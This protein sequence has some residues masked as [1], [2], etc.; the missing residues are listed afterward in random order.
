MVLERARAEGTALTYDDVRLRPDYSEVLPNQVCLESK[1]SRNVG[2]KIPIVS[3]AMDTVTEHELAIELAKL[4]GI[5]V[6]HKGMDIERQLD[7]VSKVKFHLNGLIEK[8]ICVGEDEKISSILEKREKKGYT[9]HSFLVV[10]NDEKLVGIITRNDF[11][12]WDSK[13]DVLAREIM[14]TDLFCAPGGTTI[15]DAYD[16]MRNEKKK[17][18]PLVSEKGEIAGMYVFSDVKRIKTRE[19]EAYNVDSRGQLRVAAAV[20]VGDEALERVER[21]K[22]RA[23][24]IVIDTAHGDSRG[25]FDTLR[26]IK[27]NY[28]SLDVVA[29][30]VSIGAA[31]KR[32]VD[33]GA[34][35]VKVG[36]GP[37][38]I[39][40]TRVV[41]GIGR[42]QVSAV[43]D[44]AMEIYDLGIPI[45]ADGGLTNPGDIPIAITAG[46]HSVMMGS[47]LAGTEEAPG[48]IVFAEG[49]QWKNYRGMGSV[50]A[51]RDSRGAKERYFQ[52]GSEESKLVPEGI[53]GLT[54]YKGRLADVVHQYVG[55]LRAGMGYAGTRSIK[56]LIEGGDFDRITSAGLSESHPH[57]VSMIREAPNYTPKSS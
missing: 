6:I 49:R 40:T 55:G 24:V 46:A 33:A 52:E 23:D 19:A 25:V 57:G 36:Q 13:D 17:I 42:P 7:E 26:E 14:S 54:P 37:G 1:F 43:Y 28:D 12:F 30:N 5:G 3:A 16:L 15:D 35:G 4:G 27:R 45:C 32:L 22:G 56:E 20:G 21:L 10:N 41:A 2:L 8:P 50:G 53:E 11:D 34:D 51:M 48:D 47:M 44:C 18:L 29:G 9:F 31:A 39:C 38:S